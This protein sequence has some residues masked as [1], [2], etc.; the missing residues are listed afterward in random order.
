MM[1]LGKFIDESIPEFDSNGQHVV[2][3]NIN[4]WCSPTNA[5]KKTWN[6]Y[7]SNIDDHPSNLSKS[8]SFLVDN[9][10]T[11][12]RGAVYKI[13]DEIIQIVKDLDQKIITHKKRMHCDKTQFCVC[14]VSF[15]ILCFLIPMA[16]VAKFKVT[17]IVVF[18]IG[19]IIYLCIMINL[20]FTTVQNLYR[21]SRQEAIDTFKIKQKEW[22]QKCSSIKCDVIGPFRKG[23]VTRT[24]NNNQVDGDWE[25]FILVVRI[26]VPIVQKQGVLDNE[27]T[28][29]K[30][31][32]QLQPEF[33]ADFIN[34]QNNMLQ[35]YPLQ[36][37]KYLQLTKLKSN[38][39][40]Y[41][42]TTT[43]D[44]TQTT[45]FSHNDTSTHNL[46]LQQDK[47]IESD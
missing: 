26:S 8:N 4:L 31:E 44:D 18:I 9:I 1:A 45:Y 12:Q 2:D 22:S 27:Q 32:Q 17:Y 24:T 37:K 28:E 15:I 34:F 33:V 25:K 41:S 38:A 36:M 29:T 7:T 16:V 6:I 10:D 20:R 5:S 43:T 42:V 11:E 46:L 39:K 35:K 30:L 21:K 14:F 13:R 3:C 19:F 47:E 40:E 23:K